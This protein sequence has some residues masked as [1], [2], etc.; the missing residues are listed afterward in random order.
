MAH[1]TVATLLS[2]LEQ[3][4]WVARKKGLHGKAF[5][6][7]AS[8]TDQIVRSQMA[9]FVERVFQGDIVAMVAA[10]VQIR[11][12]SADQCRRI[13]RILAAPPP[14]GSTAPTLRG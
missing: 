13:R 11:P 14:R 7:F 10:A 12:P 6:Y 3:K 4:G 8:R 9:R 1:A 5:V 2:R